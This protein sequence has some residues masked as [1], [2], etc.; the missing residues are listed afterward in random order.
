[1]AQHEEIDVGEELAVQTRFVTPE[2]SRISVLE[3]PSPPIKKKDKIIFK[4]SQT[5]KSNFSKALTKSL[6]N[7]YLTFL[8]TRP[9]GG[10]H[11]AILKV[12]FARILQDFLI[13]VNFK[14]RVVYQMDK[15]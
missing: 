1:M 15:F 6:N 7:F 13:G 2:G 3:A 8:F 12:E 5:D 14:S 11:Q 4:K 10:Y 9:P